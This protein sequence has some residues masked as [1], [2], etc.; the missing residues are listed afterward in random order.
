MPSNECT[1]PRRAENSVGS[2]SWILAQHAQA[3][4]KVLDKAFDEVNAAGVAAF[5]FGPLHAA[6]FDAGATVSFL[7]RHA[8]AHQILGVRLH[9][10]AQ[11]RIHLALHSRASQ[12]CAQP[13]T[14]ATPHPHTS[15]GLFCRISIIRTSAPPSDRPS[16][17]GGPGSKLQRVRPG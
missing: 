5:F 8:A 14:H 9:V 4:A 11:F 12:H 7:P 13:R 2:K 16:S 17:R 15:S 3:I 1:C 6:E 10:E